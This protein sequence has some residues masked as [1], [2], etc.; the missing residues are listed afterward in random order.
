LFFMLLQSFQLVDLIFFNWVLLLLTLLRR[1]GKSRLV[2]WWISEIFPS[3]FCFLAGIWECSDN[4]RRTS[5]MEIQSLSRRRRWF[6]RAECWLDRLL[7]DK[8]GFLLPLAFTPKFALEQRDKY[9]PPSLLTGLPIGNLLTSSWINLA[10]I[11]IPF[12][13][14]HMNVKMAGFAQGMKNAS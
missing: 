13:S 8:E 6:R 5:E 1:S 3:T 4:C 12:R 9:L 14:I 10:I 11:L 7:N 2:V